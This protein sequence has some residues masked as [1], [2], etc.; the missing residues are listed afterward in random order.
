MFSSLLQLA[1]LAHNWPTFS[2]EEIAKHD[3]PRSLWIVA[4]HS[5]YDVT[6]LL[7]SHVGGDTALLKRGGGV[8][9]CTEDFNFHG[10]AA[11]GEVS[12]Y[13]IGEICPADRHKPYPGPPRVTAVPPPV[14]V[15]FTSP[16]EEVD[17][18]PS[19][20]KATTHKP[21]SGT[22]EEEEDVPSSASS[23]GLSHAMP[24]SVSA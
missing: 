1:G 21:T 11:R 7:G 5:V 16:E 3:T 9:D 18:P 4:G 17:S 10:L 13:K 20:I 24:R 19:F 23:N 22:E 2:R 8:R 15:P 14:T 12:S 6:P